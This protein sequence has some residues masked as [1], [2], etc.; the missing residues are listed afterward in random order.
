MNDYVPSP[1]SPR[2]PRSLRAL[3][4]GAGDAGDDGVDA[5][6]SAPVRVEEAPLRLPPLEKEGRGG[7]ERR[8]ELVERGEVGVRETMARRPAPVIVREPKWRSLRPPLAEQ[9]RSATEGLAVV[10]RARAIVASSS[11]RAAGRGDK[12][13]LS[14]PMV[15]AQVGAVESVRGSVAGFFADRVEYEVWLRPAFVVNMEMSFADMRRVGLGRDYMRFEVTRSLEA[16]Q[17][18][19]TPSSELRLVFATPTAISLLRDAAERGGLRALF[20]LL[21]PRPS[22]PFPAPSS[23]PEKPHSHAPSLLPLSPRAP[24]PLRAERRPRTSAGPGAAS[25]ARAGVVGGERWGATTLGKAPPKRAAKVR[26][27]HLPSGSL[28]AR[29]DAALGLLPATD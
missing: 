6:S 26:L 29:L 27:H 9:L 1:R 8:T 14:L 17:G 15:S 4:A 24:S 22:P 21:P 20:A 5:K 12:P 25:G 7:I 16:F 18:R 23:V 10:E 28:R 2:S 3:G 19:H 11:G 13:L